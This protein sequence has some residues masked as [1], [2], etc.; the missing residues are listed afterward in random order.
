[1][2]R[3]GTSGPREATVPI[4]GAGPRVRKEIDMAEPIVLEVF[5]D[6]V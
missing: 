5:T 4:C 1:M 6:F 3:R 2:E